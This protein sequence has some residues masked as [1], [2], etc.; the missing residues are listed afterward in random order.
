MNE[1]DNL[2]DFVENVF[3][4]P[5]RP[6]KTIQLVLDKCTR[7]H[8][9]REGISIIFDILLRI[10][11]LSIQYLYGTDFSLTNI[12]SDQIYLLTRYFNSFGFDLHLD[13]ISNGD[14]NDNSY[15]LWFNFI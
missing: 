8:V 2:I 11:L 13:Q 1:D 6:S 3:S 15:K 12:N 10:L 14:Q 9:E 7:E 4:K 5:P